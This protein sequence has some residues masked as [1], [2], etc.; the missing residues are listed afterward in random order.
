VEKTAGYRAT[1]DECLRCAE[2]ATSVEEKARFLSMAQFWVEL[3]ERENLATISKLPTSSPD[4]EDH[5]KAG[6]NS[7]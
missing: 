4:S 7:N 1:A 2:R 3:A 5:V 6:K